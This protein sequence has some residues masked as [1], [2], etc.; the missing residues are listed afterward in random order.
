M[1]GVIRCELDTHAD[2]CAFGTDCCYVMSTTSQKVNVNGFNRSLPS[3]PDVRIGCAVVAYDCPI[4]HRTYV[5]LFEQALLVPNLDVNLLCVDQMRANDVIVNDM[6][7]QRLPPGDRKPE[8]HSI[9]SKDTDLRIPMNFE[10]PISYFNCR[11]PTREEILDVWEYDHVYLTSSEEW[12]P[13]DHRSSELE[14]NLRRELDSDF[15]YDFPV[16]EIY[17]I[18]TVESTPVGL[19]SASKLSSILENRAMVD[20]GERYF[21]FSAVKT[22]GKTSFI[23]TNHLV[24]RWR[25]SPEC[26]KRTLEKTTQR[27]V[28]DWAAI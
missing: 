24:C 4:N 8:S 1:K 12:D 2:T 18:E 9:I 3:V 5:L 6:P 21:R 14:S 7:L 25:I 20:V 28:R 16:R 13:Y 22:S 23:R 17:K 15:P 27:A 10:K 11:I 26:A 19:T